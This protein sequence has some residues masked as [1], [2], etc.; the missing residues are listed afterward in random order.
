VGNARGSS[1][2]PAADWVYRAA[3]R[4]PLTWRWGLGA[5]TALVA[6]CVLVY[7]GLLLAPPMGVRAARPL[8][9]PTEKATLSLQANVTYW[10]FQEN[11]SGL[12]VY[13]CRFGTGPV[14][15]VVPRPGNPPPSLF[16]QPPRAVTVTD[17]GRAFAFQ[18]MMSTSTTGP[19]LIYCPGDAFV[20]EVPSSSQWRVIGTTV[21]IV[22]A[23]CGVIISATRRMRRR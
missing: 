23:F 12:G 13:D 17:S 8:F 1:G 4:Q 10:F 11:H 3:V 9:G 15:N 7:V 22:V 2:D 6:V 14:S 19:T 18:M 21:V 20:V 5:G 16:Q